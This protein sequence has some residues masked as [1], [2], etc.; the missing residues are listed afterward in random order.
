MQK[1]LR[2]YPHKGKTTGPHPRH[3][4][5][6]C[7][8]EK[9]PAEGVAPSEYGA[10]LR[11]SSPVRVGVS[12]GCR[13]IEEGT[14]PLVAVQGEAVWAF[15][16]DHATSTD[17]VQGKVLR[18]VGDNPLH[19]ST[20]SV[21]S[22]KLRAGQDVYL[23]SSGGK[24]SGA[25]VGLQEEAL[26]DGT[27]ADKVYG[28]MSKHL[29]HELQVG[30]VAI[31]EQSGCQEEHRDDLFNHRLTSLGASGVKAAA[32]L[33]DMHERDSVLTEASLA[34]GGLMGGKG[35]LF[36]D[37]DN[38]LQLLK[39]HKCSLVA[40]EEDVIEISI[41]SHWDICWH[42][43]GFYGHSEASSRVHAW[44]FLRHLHG[45]LNLPWLCGG[46]F[47]EILCDSE[48]SAFTW[49]NGRNGDEIIQEML[50]R[51]V[52]SLQWFDLF[53]RSRVTHLDFWPSYHRPLIVEIVASG[54]FPA[55]SD[56]SCQIWFHFEECWTGEEACSLLLKTSGHKEAEESL[57]KESNLEW[58][59]VALWR[60]WFHC[61]S[62]VHVKLDA[63]VADILVW[64]AAF[65]E[66]FQG[67]R[68]SGKR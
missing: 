41:R 42:F 47:N 23:A 66:E 65:L 32:G 62:L 49:C 35:I 6:E 21:Q 53:D 64:S 1:H 28:A 11:A 55:R 27:H 59:L 25:R 26:G 31:V 45:F 51:C 30:S 9:Q 50:D 58:L 33:S 60:Y 44:S 63:P 37:V 43:I 7:A 8:V 17:S 48:K 29:V 14:T 16:D 34:E 12:K 67:A 61:N 18:D 2:G 68:A 10:W 39:K 19:G 4:L 24:C 52:G 5:C 56:R 15:N 13:R 3:L 40:G 38:N 36:G 57:L 46:D 22:E 20:T 54:A